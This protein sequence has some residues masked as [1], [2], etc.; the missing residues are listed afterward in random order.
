MMPIA[1]VGGWVRAKRLT[2]ALLGCVFI[3]LSVGSA[4]FT[5]PV[6]PHHIAP[7]SLAMQQEGA[8][9]QAAGELDAAIGY[10]ETALVADPRNADALI[11]L[12]DV[13]R[14]QQLPGKAIGHF[15]SALTL[16][17][18]DTRALAGQ[19]SAY[20]ARGAMGLAR[21]NL[22]ALHRACGEDSCAEIAQLS[23]AI[24]GASGRVA[25]R[26]ALRPEQVMPR[27]VI[28]ALPN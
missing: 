19:G 25:N 1:T 24:N 14:Q 22:A 20:A 21:Q 6:A 23:A 11:G 26:T 13:A 2:P 5:P 28:E 16:R 9:L 15:R 10:F 4:S 12:G 27:P 8:R 3:L 18:D 7:L 17:P